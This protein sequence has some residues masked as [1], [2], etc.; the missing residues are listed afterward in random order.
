MYGNILLAYTEREVVR[1][2]TQSNF[3]IWHWG[4]YFIIKTLFS[5]TNCQTF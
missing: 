1:C 5:K 2:Y 3:Y 4:T